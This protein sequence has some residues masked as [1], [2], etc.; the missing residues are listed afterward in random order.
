MMIWRRAIVVG[1]LS[2][3][4][5]HATAATKDDWNQCSGTAAVPA[6]AACSRIIGDESSTPQE[7]A[8]AYIWRGGVYVTT[9]DLDHAIADYGAA[10]K[11]NPQN[12]TAFGSRA[13]AEFRKGNRDAAVLD[14]STACAIDRK[15]TED[16]V[17]SNDELKQVALLAEKSPPMPEKIA[18]ILAEVAPKALSCEDGYRL[19]GAMC[20]P[21][22]CAEG[23]LRRG[24][25]CVEPSDRPVASKLNGLDLTTL[26]KKLRARYK[27][28]ESVKGI[29]I[30]NVDEKSEAAEKRLSAGDVIVEVAGEKVN[31]TSEI[32]SRMEQANADGKKMVFLS[33][34]DAEGHLRFLV[35]NLK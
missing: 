9:N 7:R 18:A 23:L 22:T 27:I 11:L 17:A 6:I 26:N 34:S 4:V 32:L 12:V 33:V 14:Y 3:L 19:E 28:K 10:I 5:S 20:V 29:L 2:L 16:L 21:V 15:G 8:D 24:N 13:I 25:D 31:N 1:V 30:T 35:L